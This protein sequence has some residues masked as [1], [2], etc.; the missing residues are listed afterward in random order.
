MSRVLVFAT[1]MTATGGIE[2]H[3]VRLCERLA[4]AGADITFLCADYRP[5]PGLDQRLRRNCGRVVALRSR[6]GRPSSATKLVWLLGAL[7]RL[8]GH[9]FTSLYLNGQGALPFWVWKGCGW[10]AR[11]SVVHHHSSGEADDVATW[12]DGYWRLLRG[13]DSVVVCS[14][15]NASSMVGIIERPVRVIYC[16]SEPCSLRTRDAMS[17]RLS[18]GFIGRL[19]PEKGVD[20]ILRLSGEPELAGIE[21]HL[22]GSLEGY[23]SGFAD[24]FPN[25]V[26]H[27]PF[28]SREGWSTLWASWTLR[29]VRPTERA[30]LCPAGSDE[31]RGSMDCIRSRWHPRLGGGCHL[32]D[33]VAQCLYLSG[34]IRC[35]KMYGAKS[36]RWFDSRRNLDPRVSE[37]IPSRIPYRAMA[38]SAPSRC[39]NSDL[40]I[41]GIT[42]FHACAYGVANYDAAYHVVGGG[43][44][45]RL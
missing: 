34:G 41:G 45:S 9:S 12:P 23:S 13:A 18:F 29:F 31:R 21:W 40:M 38:R 30:C 16:F 37:P 35:D 22:W 42:V 3:L 7:L 28:D 1:Q 36:T 14:L 32:H 6:N 17:S 33:L 11:R 27:D 24:C 44:I 2:N 8:Q 19:I 39:A 25:V 43:G 5:S 15:A 10:R 4:A 20:T 26:V